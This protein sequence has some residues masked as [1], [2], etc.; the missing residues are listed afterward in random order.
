MRRYRTW[1]SIKKADGKGWEKR[2]TKT[3]KKKVLLLVV[4]RPVAMQKEQNVLKTSQRGEENHP[5]LEKN[6]LLS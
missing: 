1:S 4:G 3:L 5:G 6:P 2:M